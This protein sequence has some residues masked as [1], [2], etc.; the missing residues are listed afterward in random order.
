MFNRLIS[1]L[2]TSISVHICAEHLLSASERD[3]RAPLWGI[4]L[5]EYQRRVTAPRLQNM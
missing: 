1:G 4:E 3:E 2:H 5:S